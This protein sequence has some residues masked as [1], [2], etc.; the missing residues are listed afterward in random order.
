[1]KK[2]IN[3]IFIIDKNILKTKQKYNLYKKYIKISD[4]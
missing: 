2:S 1:M 3:H 4:R